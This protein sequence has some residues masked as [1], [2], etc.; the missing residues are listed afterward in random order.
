L[1]RLRLG[2]GVPPN[3]DWALDIATSGGVGPYSG[4][5]L[6]SNFVNTVANRFD[7]VLSAPTVQAGAN[8]PT[9]IHFNAQGAPFGAGATVGSQYGFYAYDFV[10]ATETYGFF[11]GISAGA[12]RYGFF[13]AGLAP[14]IFRGPTLIGP[15][16]PDGS[17]FVASSV[18]GLTF[19][20]LIIN[21]QGNSGANYLDGAAHYL[22]TYNQENILV[23]NAAGSEFHRPLRW[24]TR[25]AQSVTSTVA[26]GN[27][28]WSVTSTQI[29]TPGS[30]GLA[31]VNPV[32]GEIK[33]VY[34]TG[35]TVPVMSFPAGTLQWVGGNPTT[36]GPGLISLCCVAANLVWASWT[37][38]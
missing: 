8:I 33:R 26:P 25:A 22:R 21:Y 3:A 32:V 23:M 28:D 24:Q 29:T 36:T 20:S 19:A 13:A 7:C 27:W 12:G 18:T 15:N 34:W 35:A 9:L 6:I 17:T 38:V 31:V 1:N 11:S 14:N 10:G 5:I 4:S 2:I 16:S 30:G 37:K